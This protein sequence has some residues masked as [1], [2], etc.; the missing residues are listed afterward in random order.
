MSNF[1]LKNI[2]IFNFFLNQNTKFKY[3]RLKLKNLDNIEWNFKRNKQKKSIKN[4]ENWWV[5]TKQIIRIST[6]ISNSSN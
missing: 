6:K 1:K 3:Q 4:E 5:L 2:Y